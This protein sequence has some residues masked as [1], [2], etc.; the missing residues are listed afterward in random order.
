MFV[1]CVRL[2]LRPVQLFSLLVVIVE[3]R[4]I[5]GN[6]VA[7]SN[8]LPFKAFISTTTWRPLTMASARPKP[9]IEYSI[10]FILSFSVEQKK[11][12]LE[13]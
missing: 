10:V 6:F 8:C 11:T 13:Q 7:I 1:V 5:G 4:N 9:V 3:E 12:N 2:Q